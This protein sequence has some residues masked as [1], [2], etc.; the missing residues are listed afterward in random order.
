MNTCK[1]YIRVK[2]PFKYRE[3]LNKLLNNSNIILVRQDEGRVIV[4]I[5]R[6]KIHREMNGQYKY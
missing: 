1:K 5:D 4:S 2:V 3:I 6:K